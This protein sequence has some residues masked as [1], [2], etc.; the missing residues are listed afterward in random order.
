MIKL[1]L[2]GPQILPEC[3]IFRSLA[4]NAEKGRKK[5]GFAVA[6]LIPGE[7]FWEPFWLLLAPLRAL[8]VIL[9]A[10]WARQRPCKKQS[11]QNIEKRCPREGTSGPKGIILETLWQP[12]KQRS[13]RKASL[14]R[15]E[16]GLGQTQFYADQRAPK[17][18]P[19]PSSRALPTWIRKNI[20]KS[21]QNTP[22]GCSKGAPRAPKVPPECTPQ[23]PCGPQGHQKVRLLHTSFSDGIFEPKKGPFEKRSA[24][25]ASPLS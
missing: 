11:A 12:K 25:E 15:T 21:K 7:H 5:H 24:A 6:Y 16:F 13:A 2:F 4:P 19:K 18:M 10:F 8:G 1:F 14:R 22:P 9:E 3:S 17:S 20:K 23:T